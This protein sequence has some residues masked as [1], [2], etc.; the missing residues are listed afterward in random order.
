MSEIKIVEYTQSQKGEWNA[1][2]AESNNGT[3]FHNMDFLSYHPVGKFDDRSL[4]FYKGERLI[5]VIPMA[6]F[7][8]GDKLIV[9]SPYGAS[10]GGIVEPPY[11]RFR[12]S[13]QIV[14]AMMC[15]FRDNDFHEVCITAPPTFYHR[16]QNNYVEFCMLKKGF[17]FHRREIT[18]IIP[19]EGIKNPFR[20]FEKRAKNAVRKAQKCSVTIVGDSKDYEAFYEILL[21]TKKKHNAMPTHTLKEL[22][23]IARL[24]PN[25]VKLDIA[26]LNDEPIAG[27]YYILSN[28]QV[29]DIFYT[30]YRNNFAN[31]SPLSLLL[32]YGIKWAKTAG[33]KYV[34][35]G[36]STKDMAPRSSLIMFKEGFGATGTLSDAYKWEKEK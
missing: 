16:L 6:V 5:A 11:M 31:I 19:L 9:K 12:R 3:I 8:N 25:Y 27:C 24:I 23:R 1:F 17:S 36:T 20:F 7:A 21:E 22:K 30:C 14:E 28:P 29:I 13:E 26:Y 33:F 10:F 34:D 15:Y 32:C 35:F 4:M 2:I 18:S